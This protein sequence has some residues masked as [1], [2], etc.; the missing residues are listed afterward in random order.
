MFPRMT[1]GPSKQFDREEILEKAMKL[2]WER[3]YEATGVSQLLEH[4]GIG[5]QSLYDT[6]GDKR[7]L[8]MECLGHYYETRVG[9]MIALLR[10][11]GPA[12]DNIRTFFRLIEQEAE[13]FGND[14]CLIGNCTAEMVRH[15]PEIGDRMVGYFKA[16][17]DAFADVLERARKQGEIANDTKTRDLARAFVIM[18]QGMALIGKVIPDA[19]FSK[20]VLRSAAAL[21]PVA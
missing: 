1:P 12:L 3:G 21:L 4:L 15:D 6:F 11:P 20:S 17:E 5:R 8:Y 9:P 2:F 10:K 7:S 14:G 16:M 13:S 18:L 19:K